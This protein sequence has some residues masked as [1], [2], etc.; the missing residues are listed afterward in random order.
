VLLLLLSR[1]EVQL[2][3]RSFSSWRGYTTYRQQK[4]TADEYAASVR[5]QHAFS[6]WSGLA[7]QSKQLADAADNMSARLQARSRGQLLQSSLTTWKQYAAY[8]KQKAAADDYAHAKLQ[9]QVLWGWLVLAADA[10]QRHTAAASMAAGVAAR[11]AHEMRLACF[12]G[13]QM[14]A[15]RT[16][17]VKVRKSFRHVFCSCLM[18]GG[19][20]SRCQQLVWDSNA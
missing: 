6:A 14:R 10:R 5:L 13:W 7:S 20:T 17:T 9:Q 15:V 12:A 18:L 1:S 3:R 2:L 19:R 16:R 4:A 8:R 11:A